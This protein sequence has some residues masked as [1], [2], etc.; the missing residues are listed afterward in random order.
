MPVFQPQPPA[1]A[2]LAARVK[3]SFD[4]KGLLNPGPDG[5]LTMQTT[6]TPGP[7]RRSGDRRQR[8]AAIRKCVHCG[9]C[10]ATCPTYVLLG[11]ERDS[12][13][14]RIE[15]IK[16]MLEDDRAPRR[17]SVTH[18]DRC[19]SCLACMTTC[20]SG[21]TTSSWSITAG[22]TSRSVIGGRLP[23]RLLRGLLAWLMPRPA[24]F[25]WT[26]VL[27][28]FAKPLAALLPARSADPGGAT[29]LRRLRAMLEAVPDRLR[30]PSPVDR[31]QTFPAR[32][33]AASAWR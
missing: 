15:L 5:G 28:R 10:T 29:F 31:P 13:R 17:R 12:P 20:P 8:S 32:A 21:V 14:G 11:D 1:L 16:A 27:G 30:G 7:A 4:P 18:I 25:R 26:M 19:L 24:L 2:A 23:D 33:C 9:F 6:F 22:I 3:D